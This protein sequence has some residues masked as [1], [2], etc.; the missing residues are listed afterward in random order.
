VPNS[1]GQT[2]EVDPEESWNYEFGLRSNYG[3]WQIESIGFYNDYSNLKGT[4]TFSSGCTTELDQEFN[5]GE[6]EIY[7]LEF[8]ANK[9]FKVSGGIHMPISMSY[10]YTQSE[11]QNTFRSDFS[12]WGSVESGDELPYLPD[13]QFNLQWGLGTD[14]WQ[15]AISY[16]Y[17]AKMLEA[18]GT[19]TELEG[20]S[21]DSVNQFDLSAWFQFDPSL[22]V[23]AKLD[24]LTDEVD[25]ISRRPFGARPG[26]P[27]QFILGAKYAF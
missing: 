8:S 18:A 3:D 7:G 2:G 19:G 1:P 15:V 23:Y 6:I 26:K 5:G 20:V 4:C 27:R 22:R 13:H 25:I 12:Q 21:A 9:A 11:F 16:K 17:I 24:N 14:I 10:T